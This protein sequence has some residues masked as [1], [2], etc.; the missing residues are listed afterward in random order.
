MEKKL[1][2]WV[3]ASCEL[4]GVNLGLNVYKVKPYWA[5]KDVNWK[6]FDV[7]KLSDYENLQDRIL[8]LESVLQDIA[9][10]EYN[11][12]FNLKQMTAEEMSKAAAEVLG[13][14]K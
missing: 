8:K 2:T 3:I 12:G 6:Y 7:V 1:E 10:R 13:E 9:L 5:S 4:N 14:L 11:Q